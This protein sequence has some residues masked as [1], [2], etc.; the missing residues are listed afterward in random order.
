MRLTKSEDLAGRKR[1]PAKRRKREQPTSRKAPVETSSDSSAPEDDDEDRAEADL[2]PKG[3]EA[4][5]AEKVSAM[6]KE[7]REMEDEEVRRRNAYTGAE[8]TIGSVHQ[9]KWY[10]SLDR[11]AVGYERGKGGKMVFR[12]VDATSNQEE[13]LDESKRG[14][15][16]SYPFYVKGVE[17][18]RS[19][20]TGRRGADILRDEGVESYT[21]RKGWK[22]VLN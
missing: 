22:P 5:D 11:D 8:N 13:D 3:Q 4:D 15:R 7:I 10:L 2:V 19:V 14:L 17:G 18:E 20:V 12:A 21:G 16:L 9:R 1:R 6:D